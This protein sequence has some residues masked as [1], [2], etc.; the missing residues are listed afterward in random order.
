MEKNG[1]EIRVRFDHAD[2]GLKV[3]GD[4]L[5]EFSV[6]GADRQWHW[7][8]ARID[9]DSVV[10]TSSEVTDPV[11]VRYAWQANPAATLFNGAGL[12]AAPFRTDDWPGVTDTAPAW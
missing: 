1:A 8:T 6:A 4:K 2:G 7:A 5:E 3:Q 9:G 11:A 10:V 12:P